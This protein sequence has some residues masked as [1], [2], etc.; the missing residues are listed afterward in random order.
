MNLYHLPSAQPVVGVS[1][2][3]TVGLAL[4]V[5]IFFPLN[6]LS[7]IHAALRDR[8]AAEL[9]EEAQKTSAVGD[10]QLAYIKFEA[11]ERQRA[12][13]E[14]IVIPAAKASYDL[15]I[16]SYS[17]G[18]ADYLRLNDTRSNW[19]Q[20]QK[21]DLNLLL[22]SAQLYNQITQQVGCDF[23]RQEGP[24]ACNSTTR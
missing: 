20:S 13:L 10:L 17:M 1:R 11:A 2:D 18:R 23:S 24:H 8:D 3:Y 16:K 4:S 12:N 15:T 6:E 5:P 14:R 19:I 9:Q 7:G 22:T 21:D